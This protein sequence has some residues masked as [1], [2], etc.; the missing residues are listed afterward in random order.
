MKVARSLIAG[1]VA[2]WVAWPSCLIAED[3][4]TRLV[5]IVV[6]QSAGGATDTFA[7]VIGQKLSER[8]KQPVVVENR[9]GAAGVIGSDSVAKAPADGYTLL[10]TYEGS[11]AINPSLYENLPFDSIKDFTPIATIAVTPFLLIVGPKVQAKTFQEF[12]ALAR[13]NPDK[14]NYGSS[15]NGSVNHLLG[16]MLKVEADIRITHVP[17]KGAAQSISDVIGGHL[18]SAFASAPSVISSVQQGLVRALAVSSGKRVAISP[19][20]PTIAEGGVR[21]F[22]VNPWWGIFGPAGLPPSIVSKIN[23]D[24]AEILKAPDVLELLAKQGGTPLVSSPDEF[25]TLLAKDIAKWAKTVKAAGVKA[26]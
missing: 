24:V 17:Y 26:N 1:V 22:D 4:P 11:Q 8:W 16:E 10:V 14:L 5:H 2:A 12:L 20:T 25:R 18:D 19:D 13:A 7:R 9:A 6:P 23:A 15:G 21:D 3:Y